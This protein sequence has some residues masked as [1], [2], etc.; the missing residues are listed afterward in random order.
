MSRAGIP[1]KT[2]L[3]V[4]KISPARISGAEDTMTN[5]TQFVVFSDSRESIGRAEVVSGFS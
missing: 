1:G 3:E 2:L 4:L 5:A